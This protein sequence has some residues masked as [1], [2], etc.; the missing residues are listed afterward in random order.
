MITRYSPMSLAHHKRT[1]GE[2]REKRATRRLKSEGQK[3][4]NSEFR[5]QNFRSRQ[6]RAYRVVLQSVGVE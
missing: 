3:T 1:T 2:T 4:Q 5:T 6:S